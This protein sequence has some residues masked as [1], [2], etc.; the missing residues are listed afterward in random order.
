MRK[1]NTLTERNV[2][3]LLDKLRGLFA[4]I[5]AKDI[6]IKSVVTLTK[7]RTM[8]QAKELMRICKISGI[9]VTDGNN[10]LEGIVSIEDIIDA[11]EGNYITDPIE[12]HMTRNIVTFSPEMKLESVIE[13]FNRYRYGRFPVVDSDGRLVGIISKKDIISAILDKFRL[14]YVHDKR[15]KEVLEQS[16]DWFDKSLITGDYVEKTSADFVYHIDYTDIDTAGVGSAKLKSFLKTLTDDDR[17]IR[18]VSIACYEAEV[19]VVIHS[20]SEGYIFAW[21]DENVTRVRVEDYGRGI[22]NVEQAMKE[23]FS[24]A[25]DHVRELGFGAGMGLSNMRRY[26]DKMVVVSE[27]GKGVV[28]EMHFYRNGRK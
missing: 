1:G 4:D 8:W 9:P 18:R 12:K 24:T 7:D 2:D 11:L 10:Q 15:R 22:E 17:L 23:G 19:N 28:L 16:V 5:T 25:S 21:Y 6:M 3:D 20:G 13:M 26:S 14:I 27:A